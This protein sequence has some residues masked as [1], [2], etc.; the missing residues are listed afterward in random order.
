[1]T[2]TISFV[3]LK[4]LF[5]FWVF[6]NFENKTLGSFQ[7]ALGFISKWVMVQWRVHQGS[8]D[9]PSNELS[10]TLNWTTTHFE[11]NPKSTL[12]WTQGPI[13]RVE[14]PIKSML[15][16]FCYGQKL[17]LNLGIPSNPTLRIQ[18]VRN[19]YFCIHHRKKSRKRETLY[20][21]TCADR[22]TNTGF[23]SQVSGDMCH[24]SSFT[25]ANSHSHVP[26]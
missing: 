18:M 13:F 16:F 23:M 9:T 2:F 5:S 12:K 14:K 22:G 6:F 25:N 4:H 21:L 26:F 7:S 24:M 19:I 10:C 8:F 15:N 11:M 1:M 17:I 20:L 3:F